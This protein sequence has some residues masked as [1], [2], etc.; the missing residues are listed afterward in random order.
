MNFCMEDSKRKTINK[1]FYRFL[2]AI[3]IA[4][5]LYILSAV[6]LIATFKVTSDSMLPILHTN[7]KIL[8]FKPTIGARL[9]DI[10]AAVR[11]KP[12]NVYRTKGMRTIRYND[13]VV[14]NYPYTE[15][16]NWDSIEMDLRKYYVKRCIGLPGDSIFS[17]NGIYGIKGN[18]RTLGNTT[19]Q[20]EAY[21]DSSYIEQYGKAFVDNPHLEWDLYNWG[22]IYIP[23]KGERI[24]ITVN[25]CK[26]YKSIIEWET[27]TRMEDVLD[28]EMCNGKVIK[29][30]TFKHDYYFMAGD[31]VAHSIDSRYWGFVPD[32]FIVGVTSY[33][34]GRVDTND[35][36]NRIIFRKIN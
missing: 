26:I 33:V 28:T 22:P 7:D 29:Q 23:R 13:V 35:Y 2:C 11:G 17:V 36:K 10:L 9:F 14:F 15:W 24:P 27:D 32:V 5:A 1:I 20:F 34:I 6:F 30:Y 19:N 3:S 8:V 21:R 25:N 31:N 4:V 16:N 12:F 18:K